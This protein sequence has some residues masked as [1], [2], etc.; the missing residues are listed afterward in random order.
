MSGIVSGKV[1]VVTGAGGGI[2][3]GIALAMARAGA[4]VVVN[5]IGVSLT[6]EGG[7]D[8]PAHAVA[9]E[10][11]AA[12]GQAVANTDSVAAYDSASRVIQA[13]VDAFGR[14]DAVVNN[15]GNLRDRVFHKMSEEEWRQVIDVHLN[16]SFF[17]SRA[18]A[19]YFREQESGAFVHMT[20]T[21]GLIGNFGQ[22]NY[23]AAKL[24]IVALSKSIA[25][26]MARYNVRSNCIAPFAWSRM[27]SSIPAETDEEKARVEKLKKMEADKVAPMA[28][29]LASDAAS[30]ITAQVFAVR[31][32]E[33]MLMS[34]PRPLRSVHYSEGWTPELIGEIAVPAMR[35]HFYALERSPDV[36][37]WDPI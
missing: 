19:P 3:R 31:A 32:N 23:A 22:A 33:I 7:G 20:S 18:A 30:A 28:V 8:G 25:L 36:I 1:V 27:T 10:I 4:K 14:I 17:M 9:R 11:A 35:K 13:A 16:G 2:G 5:D 24:G 37:D 12:G 29:Y 21:S 15:A 26:D 34:Q 6:G